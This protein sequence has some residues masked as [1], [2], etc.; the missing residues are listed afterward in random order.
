MSRDTIGRTKAQAASVHSETLAPPAISR[1]LLGLFGRY[2]NSYI[3]RHFHSVRLLENSAPRTN[4]SLPLVVY[5]NHSSWWDPLLCLHLARRF[6]PKRQAYGPIEANALRRY[7]F[8]SRLGFFGVDRNS[9]GGGRNFL[10][11]A[12]AILSS[13]G[14]AIWITPQGRFTDYHARPVQLEHGLSHLTKVAPRIAFVPL[15]L[16]YVHWEERLPEILVGFGDQIIFDSHQVMSTAESTRLFE[17]GLTSVQDHLAAA[18]ARRAPEEWR[19][20][21][22]GRGGVTRLYDGWRH[23]KARWRGERFDPAHSDL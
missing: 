8:L 19:V 9:T 3:R 7:Q 22:S 1:G 17:S 12:G 23:L 18:S 2:S 10:R 15:A 11:T 13:P 5:L 20:L 4:D 21:L 14:N 16:Q 6:F